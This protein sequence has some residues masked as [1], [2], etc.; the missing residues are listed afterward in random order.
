MY[1]TFIDHYKEL[2]EEFQSLPKTA[3]DFLNKY[4]NDCEYDVLL[5]KFFEYSLA[6]NLL[7]EVSTSIFLAKSAFFMANKNFISQ[8]LIEISA[9]VIL[10][11]LGYLLLSTLEESLPRLNSSAPIMSNTELIIIMAWQ[12]FRDGRYDRVNGLLTNLSFDFTS[13]EEDPL[14]VVI[15]IFILLISTIETRTI[16]E[17]SHWKESAKSL[18]VQ[19][20]YYDHRYFSGLL[21]M[22]IGVW[23]NYF[24][25]KAESQR[26]LESSW[27]KL[28]NFS[29]YYFLFQIG[30]N[31]GLLAQKERNYDKACQMF[32]RLLTI[33][34]QMPD[35]LS[36]Y[37][38]ENN[39][40]NLYY[41][42]GDLEEAL[43]YAKEAENLF[44]EKRIP[45]VDAIYTLAELYA[46]NGLLEEATRTI[47][48]G[49]SVRW[50][51]E[52]EI[53][54][55]EYFR[56]L[57]TIEKYACNFSI[58]IDQ[59]LEALRRFKKAKDLNNIFECLMELVILYLIIFYWRRQDS[60]L[61]LANITADEL[62]VLVEG[63]EVVGWSYISKVT[64]AITKSFTNQ[65]TEANK[66]VN[67]AQQSKDLE[68]FSE[69]NIRLLKLNLAEVPNLKSIA[70]ESIDFLTNLLPHR[71]R[72]TIEDRETRLLS[73]IVLDSES[74]LPVFVY[75]FDESFKIDRLLLSGLISA[76][77]TMSRS[78]S[79]KELDEIH[80][81]DSIVL[82][83]H[84]DP[85]IFAIVCDEH[86]TV[87]LRLKLLQLTEK[88]PD[89][90]IGESKFQMDFSENEEI[91]KLV[92]ETFLEEKR[93][94]K[95]LF[96]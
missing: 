91:I 92:K 95:L 37:R 72:W 38:V 47:E 87:S 21:E 48:N 18:L 44:Y 20:V 82:V 84:R 71:S 94:S 57:A 66:L 17:A 34:D 4:H 63:Q 80:Y 78:L 2:E 53:E 93:T 58:A 10:S 42:L 51:P 85:L 6:T 28:E 30:E 46:A 67:D 8:I 27:R 89:Y 32:T 7:P 90:T 55:P 24:G 88:F 61:E 64:L 76:M 81:R 54:Q 79:L 96:K 9:D 83:G 62:R 19:S 45:L 16:E 11:K 5:L 73:L 86:V 14:L 13:E 56:A 68:F 39:L 35:S 65:L 75:Y 12:E 1:K 59:F 22:G 26:Y 52:T 29:N 69:E 15:Y 36:I 50:I 3:S 74:S 60:K 25:D 33:K 70:L 23:E 41:N 40:A 31:L 43:K 77:N 49:L